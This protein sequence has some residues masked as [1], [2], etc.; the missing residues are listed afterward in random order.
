[1]AVG[2]ITE[3]TV[4]GRAGNN[5]FNMVFH[6]ETLTSFGP[7]EGEFLGL[8]EAVEEFWFLK[9]ITDDILDFTGAGTYFDGLRL[10]DVADPSIGL[11]WAFSPSYQGA[12]PNDR[13]SQQVCMLIQKKT[14]KIGRSY[15]GRTYLPVGTETV[16]NGGVWDG[17]F[18]TDVVDW[19]TTLLGIYNSALT[20]TFQMVV[21]SELLQEANPVINVGSIGRTRTQR[22]RSY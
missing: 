2:D 3:V 11:D 5:D 12:V 22:R 8:V 21:W 7:K 9:T 16:C 20:F 13:L 14:Q 19:Y 15:S 18:R 10:R 6:Y 17:T 1:M 4:L